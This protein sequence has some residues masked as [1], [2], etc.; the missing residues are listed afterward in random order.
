MAKVLFVKGT[1]QSE[2][3]SKSTQVARTFINQ[4][5]EVNPTD[6][7]VELDLYETGVPLID[8]D[9]LS[10]WNNLRNNEALTAV[11]SQKVTAINELTEQF[12]QAEKCI[13]QSSLWNLGIQPLLKAYFDTIVLAGTTFKYTETGPVGLM[14]GKKVIHIHGS[15]GVYSNTTGIEHADSYI[16]SVLAFIGCEVLPTI[17]V[18]GIDHD[19]SQKETIM[20]AAKAKAQEVAKQF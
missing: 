3:Q 6:E 7:V 8:A 18:E 12:V 17:F 11:E 16:K 10:G 14:N 2:E 9:V 4:Y 5:K 1:P 19:P 20:A 15:G 13:F